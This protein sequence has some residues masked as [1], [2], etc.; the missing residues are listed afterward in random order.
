FIAIAL[1]NSAVGFLGFLI[2]II[3]LARGRKALVMAMPLLIGVLT[4]S[5][6]I[7]DDHFRLRVDDSVRVLREASVV[8]VNPSTYALLS[9]AFVSWSAFNDRPL[10]G[11]GIGAHQIAH[12]TY[13]PELRGT[14][15]MED[16]YLKYNAKDANSLFLRATSEL[17]IVGLIFI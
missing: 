12:D 9:N 16:E 5:F 6:Y 13:L 15:T 14:E 7:F 17:G 2:A 8:D 10:F 1:S 3:Q 11:F 4:A